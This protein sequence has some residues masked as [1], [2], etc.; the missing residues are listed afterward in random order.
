M[1]INETHYKKTLNPFAEKS[2]IDLI[3]FGYTYRALINE[4]ELTKKQ[5]FDDFRRDSGYS[6]DEFSNVT[7]NQCYNRFMQLAKQGY[8]KGLSRALCD[9]NECD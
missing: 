1:L 4:K 8:L 5:I 9:L 3:F 2:A 7:A 6:I